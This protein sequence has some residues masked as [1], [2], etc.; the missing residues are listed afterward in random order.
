MSVLEKII[1]WYATLS[2]DTL[3]DI[4]DIYAAR[5]RFKDPFNAVEGVAEI[6][7]IFLH[8]FATTD[9][10]HFIFIDHFQQENQAFLSWHFV[11]GL[12]GKS[13]TVKGATH[14]R[15]DPYGKVVEHRDYWDPAEE[16][17]QKLPFIGVIVGWLRAKFKAS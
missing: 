3:P 17:W 14:L 10:P 16:L 2:L 1:E 15:F 5:A 12:N 7:K 4:V 6:E 13:Y 9:K 8:M 11:F